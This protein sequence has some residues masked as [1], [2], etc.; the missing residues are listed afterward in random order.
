[1]GRNRLRFTAKNYGGSYR[2][3]DNDE[4][5]SDAEKERTK[6]FLK[7]KIKDMMKYGMPTLEKFP[8][9]SREIADEMRRQ[10]IT[11]LGLAIEL[12]KKYYKKTTLRDLDVALAKLKELLDV[13]SDRDYYRKEAPPLS[14]HQREVWSRLN[15]E[16]GK[17]IGGYL[18]SLEEGSA[19]KSEGTG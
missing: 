13:A 7:D 9:R 8:R 11:M 2:A 6:V 4:P 17:M 1:M 5:L 3:P 18:Q 19:D 16:I 14:L 15:E 10:M 12:N